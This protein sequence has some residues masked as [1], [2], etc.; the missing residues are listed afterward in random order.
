MFVLKGVAV[1]LRNK[2]Q[3]NVEASSE[4]ETLGS[5]CSYPR[6]AMAAEAGDGP[7]ACP[8]MGAGVHGFLETIESRPQEH[9]VNTTGAH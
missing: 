3:Q 4:A 7:R 8:A 1:S 2:L 5:Q 9:D 6:G